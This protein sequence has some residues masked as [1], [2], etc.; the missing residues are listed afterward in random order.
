MST[1]TV[2]GTYGSG[3]TPAEIYIYDQRD[4]SA[5]YAVDGSKNVNRAAN[6]DDL[7]EGVNVEEVKDIDT[8][9]AANAIESVG[10]LRACIDEEDEEDEEERQRVERAIDA[11]RDYLD[12]VQADLI[13]DGTFRKDLAAARQALNDSADLYCKDQSIIWSRADISDE[14]QEEIRD[15]IDD[16]AAQ[17]HPR[18]EN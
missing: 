11:G 12:S 4:G 6:S 5:W 9:T 8:C 7:Q 15:A 13:A 16:Y 1:R 2:N 10:D 18:P 3:R 17:L 14:D